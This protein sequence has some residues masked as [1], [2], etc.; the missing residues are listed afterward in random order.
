[1]G[2]L[3]EPTSTREPKAPLIGS[4]SSQ[5]AVYNHVTMVCIS[6]QFNL[7]FRILCAMFNEVYFLCAPS[8]NLSTSS[9]KKLIRN[10]S[11]SSQKQEQETESAC[12]HILLS[13]RK[14]TKTDPR[15]RK[16]G[17]ILLQ[18]ILNNFTNLWM[19][20]ETQRHRTDDR[21]FTSSVRANDNV[22]SRSREDFAM[23]IC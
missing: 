17:C 21:T 20:P 15:V 1:M 14:K 5:V 12:L 19:G 23:V 10:I 18:N 8:Q 2:R 13:F 6:L 4:L 16:E 3:A 9:G 7:E 11:P 22:Q